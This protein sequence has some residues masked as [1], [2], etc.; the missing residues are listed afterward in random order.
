MLSHFCHAQLC[1]FMDH[2]SS[3]G[4]FRQEYW[5]GLPCPLPKDLPHPGIK[6]LSLE[7]PVLAGRFFTTSATWEALKLKK[8]LISFLAYQIIIYK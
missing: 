5:S 6:L 1:D 3:M 8:N 4:F 2:S 7:S